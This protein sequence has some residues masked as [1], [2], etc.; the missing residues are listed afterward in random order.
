[1]SL[2]R[3]CDPASDLGPDPG[4]SRLGRRRRQEGRGQQGR[5]ADDPRHHLGSDRHGRDRRRLQHAQGR[6]RRSDVLD[7]HRPP[8]EPGVIAEGRRQASNDKNRDRD[9]N[10]TANDSSRSGERPRHRMN[11]YVVAISPKTKVCE[12]KETG[13]E[14]SASVKEEACGFDKLEIGDRVEVSFNSKAT[15]NASDNKDARAYAEARPPSDLLR[16][17]DRRQDPRRAD[18]KRTPRLDEEVVAERRHPS[19]NSSSRVRGRRG[20]LRPS[21]KPPPGA[22]RPTHVWR[23]IRARRRPRSGAASRRKS[24]AR[25]AA[26]RRSPR[27]IPTSN[28]S[29]RPWPACPRPG[30]AG[31]RPA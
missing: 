30:R 9:V 12:C 5:R 28:H 19:P 1:M 8:L 7:H 22:Y 29:G 17:R 10:R 4:P 31:C 21:F 16:Q 20:S 3:N 23:T 13:K 27:R 6:H 24:W 14:G 26:P 18:G 11:V 25:P 2:L 15:S